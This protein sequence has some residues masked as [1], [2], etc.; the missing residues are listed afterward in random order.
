MIAGTEWNRPK[1]Q[2]IHFEPTWPWLLLVALF[3][4]CAG[5][6]GG[7]GK[8]S[9]TPPSELSYLQSN[10]VY[11]INTFGPR[12]IPTWSGGKPTAF[13]MSPTLPAGL[14]LDPL[15][16]VISGTPTRVA[17]Q[18]SYAVTAM[19]SAG[20]TTAVLE[21]AVADSTGTWLQNVSSSYRTAPGGL[22][23]TFATYQDADILLAGIDFNNTGG[24]GL[25]NHTGTVSS[26]GTHLVLVDRNNNRVL[27]WNTLPSSNVPPDFVLGQPDFTSNN[28]GTGLNQLNWP[29]SVS[30][31]GGRL[32][33]ADAFN[34]RILLWDS[35]PSST[36]QPA[37]RSVSQLWPWGVWTDGTKVAATETQGQPGDNVNLWNSWP[38]RTDQAPDL[39]IHGQAIGMGTPRTITSNG[40]Y[41]V[42]GDHNASI[43]AYPDT[44]FFWTSWP[45]QPD[46]APTFFR[47]DPQQPGS[48]WMQGSITSD[49]RL[50]ML[51]VQDLP[52]WDAL[53]MTA[54]TAPDLIVGASGP[55][56]PGFLFAGGNGSGA[57]FAGGRLYVSMSNGN[58]V[59]GFNGLPTSATQM[60][61]FVLGAPDIHT[62]TL[63]S[64]GLI[65]NPNPKSDGT[66][67]FALSDFDYA[68]YVWKTRP[69]NSGALPDY[70]FHT[71]A[72]GW[73]L[74][75]SG[76][77]I[78]VAGVSTVLGWTSG[79]PST[80]AYPDFSLSGNVG[81]VQFQNLQGVSWDGTWFALS[82]SGANRIYVWNGIPNPS[83]DPDHVIATGPT[84]TSAVGRLSSNGTTL[85][86]VLT[87]DH[88][89]ALYDLTNFDSPP[90]YVDG[91]FNG[92]VT[93]IRFNLPVGAALSGTRLFVADTAFNRVQIWNDLSTAVA[94]S[95][96]D[97]ILGQPANSI[98]DTS[99]AMSRNG[100]FFPGAVFFDGS[101][102]WVGEFKFSGRLV[103][104]SVH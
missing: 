99:P 40:N 90:R 62:N 63:L 78:F 66:A 57:C 35:F 83:R 96:P 87:L 86:A 27:V 37:T 48:T 17:A 73:D 64:H 85:A 65:T 42:V 54:T 59:V 21:I 29:V 45:T 102:L 34:N 15:T 1:T 39:V 16:G 5:G 75:V 20:S 76:G 82:D 24:P 22:T 100:L 18:G 30:A 92:N 46:Q 53:P 68:L 95:A 13:T 14:G 6:G 103:R 79:L 69:D 9:V 98:T 2:G 52:L 104:F 19:N 58:R 49:G 31:A 77:K 25:Y 36:Q 32:A 26:D 38:T 61:D 23:G 56:A 10:F 3:S 33:V 81:A 55:G 88:K 44:N 50:V 67:L 94:G 97:I 41:L 4:S 93:P 43:G 70:I 11:T 71:A 72:P 101:Y 89:I 91:S 12:N 51:A 60:P 84:G 80:G 28:P 7:G 74:A 8:G 47:S